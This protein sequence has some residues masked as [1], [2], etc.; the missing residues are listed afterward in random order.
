MS[1]KAW[2]IVLGI[3]LVVW[4]LHAITNIRFD[5]QNLIEGI[6]AVAAAILLFLDR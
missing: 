1:R 4:A 2:A 6:L 5:G 3:F